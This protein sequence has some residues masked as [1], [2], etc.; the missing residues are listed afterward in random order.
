MEKSYNGRGDMKSTDQTKVE[1]YMV[2]DEKHYKIDCP[3]C[4][5]DGCTCCGFSGEV[6]V[7]E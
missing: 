5:G 7:D 1:N 2:R 6:R 4:N 3:D